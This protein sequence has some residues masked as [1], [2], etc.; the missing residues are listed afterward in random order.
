MYVRKRILCVADPI[1]QMQTTEK[2]T[3]TKHKQF[4]TF[5]FNSL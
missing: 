4:N 3:I 5:N 2:Q 1:T